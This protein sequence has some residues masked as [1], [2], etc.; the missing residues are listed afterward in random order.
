MA[1]PID[2]GA[3]RVSVD[4]PVRGDLR[5]KWNSL[6]VVWLNNPQTN[7]FLAKGNLPIGWSTSENA[8]S[9]ENAAFDYDMRSFYVL[10]AQGM[11]RAEVRMKTAIYDQWAAVDLISED[12]PKNTEATSARDPRLEKE[13]KSL[14]LRYNTAVT[15]GHGKGARGQ[16]DVD[17]A[18]YE[19]V[20]F[21]KFHP[22]FG[23]EVPF[24]KH[25]CHDDG[26]DGLS[27][28]LMT[29]ARL[30]NGED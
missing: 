28:A 13:M 20:E 23:G 24:A 10:D 11:Y 1:S 19:L 25:Q 22:Y 29:M 7:A 16:E 4:L 14:I 30:L 8:A 2:E 5:G 6:G 17:R 12:D 18:Y 3:T 21:V 15:K 26:V 27:Q 9:D